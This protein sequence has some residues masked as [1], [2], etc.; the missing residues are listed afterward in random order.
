L[1]LRIVLEVKPDCRRLVPGVSARW[2]AGDLAGADATRLSSQPSNEAPAP[3]LAG[4]RDV[5][6][7][8]TMELTMAQTTTDHDT[9]RKWAEAREGRPARVKGTG[10]AKD[11]GLLRLDFGKPE[12]NLEAITWDEFFEKFEESELAL[13]YEDEPE[14]R[15]SKLVRR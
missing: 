4:W 3:E 2:D 15:F 10:D 13:L 8:V 5:L 14:N 12:E 1:D 9:I 6:R 7:A 11:A